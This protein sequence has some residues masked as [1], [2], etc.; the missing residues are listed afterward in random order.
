MS[1]LMIKVLPFNYTSSM[2]FWK[3]RKKQVTKKKIT[4]ITNA[5]IFVKGPD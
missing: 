3:E 2:T 5:G 1:R 4:K